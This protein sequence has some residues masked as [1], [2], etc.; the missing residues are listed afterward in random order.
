MKKPKFVFKINHNN[1]AKV[2]INGK[3]QKKVTSIEIHGEPKSF[4][5]DIEQYKT[6]KKGL[7]IVTES[8]EIEKTN[9]HYHIGDD[10]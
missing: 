9:S 2:Y 8:N 6:D 3:W 4:D 1:T 5:I 7:L 10:K